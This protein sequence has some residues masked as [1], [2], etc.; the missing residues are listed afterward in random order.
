MMSSWST[1]T[2]AVCIPQVLLDDAL[3]EVTAQEKMEGWIMSEVSKGAPLS[4]LYS[5]KA[6]IKVS[7]EAWEKGK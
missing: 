2:S 7:C 5:M 6:E 3:A 1:R 4:G